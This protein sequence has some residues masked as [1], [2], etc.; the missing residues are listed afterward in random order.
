MGKS[1]IPVAVALGG[2]CIGVSGCG[3]T[4]AKTLDQTSVQD[5]ISSWLAARYGV[6]VDAVSCPPSVPARAGETFQCSTTVAGKQVT[7]LATVADTAGNFHVALGAA[8]INSKSAGEALSKNLGKTA[9]RPVTVSCGTDTST[10]QVVAPG[11]SFTCTATISG[12]KPVQLTATATRADAK[13]NVQLSVGPTPPAA[14]PP[15]TTPVTAPTQPAQTAPTTP[16]D[17]T[18]T[19]P[20]TTPAT[21]PPDTTPP[22]TTPPD[23][24]PA[25]T[26]PDT[27]PPA[28][29]PPDT[30]PTTSGGTNNG[31]LGGGNAQSSTSGD[32]ST[33]TTLPAVSSQAADPTTTVD[34]SATT[35]TT[36]PGS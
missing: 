30:T 26:P 10:V 28:T 2:I 4:P 9:G 14:T 12:Q 27:T 15:A 18:P 11:G 36:T 35:S 3:V 20:D 16:V 19:V 7:L 8:I 13:G 25:T 21:T 5:H 32:D 24:T 1:F 17:T 34:P 33:V 23:T 22:A 31:L 29:T 6:N